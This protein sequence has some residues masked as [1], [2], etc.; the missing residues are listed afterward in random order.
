[1]RAIIP[2]TGGAQ[3]TVWP[4]ANVD[5]HCKKKNK[6]K[7]LCLI[8]DGSA[9]VH[10]NTKT[11]SSTGPC[12]LRTQSAVI[13]NKHKYDIVYV[14]SFSSVAAAETVKTMALG[15]NFLY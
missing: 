2:Q 7:K 1:M 8:G 10:P 6:K 13:G 12:V 15:H 4:R 14:Y 11:P 5:L 3:A 9:L